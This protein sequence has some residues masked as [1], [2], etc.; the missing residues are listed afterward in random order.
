MCVVERQSRH[1]L[2]ER[3]SQQI[4]VAVKAIGVNRLPAPADAGQVV[5]EGGTKIDADASKHRSVRYDRAGELVDQL[6][7]EISA[8]MATLGKMDYFVQGVSSRLPN[9]K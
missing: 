6:K 9:A 1:A 2:C 4:A 5:W 3:R 7:L 8:L